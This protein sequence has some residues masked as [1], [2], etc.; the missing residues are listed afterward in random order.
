MASSAWQSARAVSSH[1]R[2]AR[3]VAAAVAPGAKC[4]AG[5][6]LGRACAC[7]GSCGGRR[8]SG[9]C[10]PAP[11]CVSTETPSVTRRALAPCPLWQSPAWRVPAQSTRHRR[12]QAPAVR[13]QAPPW[14]VAG[15]DARVPVARA[16]LHLLK[17]APR[18]LKNAEISR[19][20]AAER[21]AQEAKGSR[22]Q[23]RLQ[24]RRTHAC[25]KCASAADGAARSNAQQGE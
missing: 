20:A 12:P 24:N 3:W 7:A 4:R 6:L 14:S 23:M 22:V 5:S 13:L 8:S 11:P 19:H 10:S 15:E 17:A 1:S 25:G 2:G 18:S 9:W 16:L 21:N